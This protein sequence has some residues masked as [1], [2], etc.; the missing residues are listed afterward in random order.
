[1]RFLL[2]LAAVLAVVTPVAAQTAKGKPKRP[3]AASKA[4]PDIPSKLP[5][6]TP[7]VKVNGQAIPLSLYVDRLSLRYG[8]ELREILIEEQLIRQ[9]CARRK[10][11]V[12]PQDIDAA[13]ERTYS[14]TVANYGSEAQLAKEL[15]RSRG[16]TPDDYRAVIRSQVDIQV[17]KEKLAAGLVKASEI[18]DADVEARYNERKQSFVQPDMVRVSHILVKKTADGDPDKEKAQRAKADDLLKKIVAAEGKNFEDLARESSDDPATSIRGGRVPVDLA[19]GAHPFG[20]AFDATVYAAPVGLIKQVIPGPD[21]YHIVR[22][23]SKKEGRV[24]Q[25]ADVK[26]QLVASMLAEQRERILAELLLKLRGS[27]KV[28]SGKF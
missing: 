19:R 28:D 1:M 16:W 24:L 8:P 10:I 4:G 18:K 6:S 25:L 2:P 22:V 23:D 9:E 14:A 3:A 5:L 7:L 13:V 11:T 27:A 17:L 26:E 12:T 20:G 21:G 15:S